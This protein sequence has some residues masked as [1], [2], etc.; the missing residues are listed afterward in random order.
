MTATSDR[1]D[2]SILTSAQPGALTQLLWI[3]GF[4]AATAAGARLE[5]EHTPVPYTLQTL[6]V[7]LAGAFLGPRNGAA[8]QLLYL[9]AG[10]LGAPVFSSGTFGIARLL[11]PTGGYLLAFPIAAYVVGSLVERKR[12][13]GWCVLS[14][15]T[16]LLVIFLLGA[17]YLS[18]VH[19]RSFSAGFTS[20]FLLFSWWDLLKL[21][22]AAAIYFEIAKRWPRL[23]V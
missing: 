23:P 22:A 12:A 11:G 15:G 20:G 8:S 1:T 5:I 16:G 4:A 10:V 18:A 6:M 13:L 21:G 14:M 2:S 19:L 3:V 9:A 17:G 7:L